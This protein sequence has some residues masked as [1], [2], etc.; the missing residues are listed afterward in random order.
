MEKKNNWLIDF[1][2][3]SSL[4]TGILPGVS[5]GTVGLIV[6]IY[7]KMISN[8]DNL[9]K[10]GQFKKSFI[11]LI[12]IFLGLAIFTVLLMIFWDSIASEYFPFLTICILAGFV[13]GG[14]PLLYQ[15]IKGNKPTFAGILRLGISF[16]VTAAIGVAAFIMSYYFFHNQ[17]AET[18]FFQN[19]Q[20]AVYYPF[21]APWIYPILFAMGL[22]SAIASIV[23]GVSGAMIMFI[24]G[25]YN[26]I[27]SILID[28]NV[29]VLI[30][31]QSYF[32][33]LW[34]AKVS[35]LLVLVLGILI[36]FVATSAI[37]K[38]MLASHRVGTFQIV[39]GFVLGSLV[40]MF[41]NNDMYSVYFGWDSFNWQMV[42]GPLALIGTMF[43]TYYLIKRQQNKKKILLEE[44]S[45]SLEAEQQD[46]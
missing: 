11:N 19:M 42:V 38:K 18:T 34:W 5:M 45:S 46:S 12:P 21:D 41:F 35:G 9:R 13:I 14:F 4:G 44:P 36:G 39:C 37:M 2:K 30:N 3:G 33:E 7:D 15:E 25:L 26:P 31:F 10:K 43:L 29:S 23:P 1:L 24:T 32:S 6:D 40:S 22:V 16:L 28:K 20:M 27:I 8:V 17:T